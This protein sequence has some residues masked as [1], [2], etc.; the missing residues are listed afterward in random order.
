MVLLSG[1]DEVV[2]IGAPSAAEFHTNDIETQRRRS[3]QRIPFFSL[4][5]L[6]SVVFECLLDPPWNSSAF[7]SSPCGFR[8]CFQP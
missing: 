6:V 1:A 5:S 2:T 4:E 8:A 3:S 7:T